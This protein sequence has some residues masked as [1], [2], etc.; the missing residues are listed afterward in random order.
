MHWCYKAKKVSWLFWLAVL[1]TLLTSSPSHAQ[2]STAFQAQQFRPWLD[3]NGLFQTQS[4]ATL[5]QFN[6]TLGFMANY[7]YKPLVLRDAKQ[8]DKEIVSLLGS[9]IGGDLVLGFGLF[10]ILDILVHLP[11]TMYQTG[12]FPRDQTFG[13]RLGDSLNGSYLGDLRLALKLG[14]L[15]DRK[16]GVALALMG[17]VPS[18]P[19]VAEKTKTSTVKMALPSVVN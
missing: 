6:F 7:A 3:P 8:A 13:S 15:D 2:N 17:Y 10:P 16:H 18:L 5:E 12:D 11:V 14:I 4:A 19:L 1:L 9:Q